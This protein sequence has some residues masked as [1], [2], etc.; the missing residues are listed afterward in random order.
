MKATISIFILITTIIFSCE[1]IIEEKSTSEK[2]PVKENIIETKLNDEQI[3]INDNLP[4]PSVEVI[5]ANL[6]LRLDLIDFKNNVLPVSDEIS[7][8][9]G[10]VIKEYFFD[11]C[12]GDKD[13]PF[14][15][16]DIYL[17]T[18]QINTNSN[19]ILYLVIF[20]FITGKINSYI[21]FFDNTKKEFSE[22]VHDF[23]IH[24]LYQK[25]DN[26]LKP[27]NLKELFK[28]NIPEIEMVDFDGDKVEDFKLT[29]LYHNGTANAIEEM[30]IEVK[31]ETV[32]TLKFE[33]RWIYN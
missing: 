3:V 29:R 25:K 21:L 30:I 1:K 31:D 16:K 7:S 5:E 2:I 32:D 11:I 22:Y 4:P 27:S 6:P 23:N 14:S 10:A 17:N 9:I 33:R 20:R 8:R 18:I 26:H 24:A 15:I 13:C 19:Q 28:I 12:E